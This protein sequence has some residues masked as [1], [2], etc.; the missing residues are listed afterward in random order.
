MDN[1]LAKHL[2]D[3]FLLLKK[4][5]TVNQ[6]IIEYGNFEIFDNKY[7]LEINKN[8]IVSERVGYW[9]DKPVLLFNNYKYVLLE[10]SHNI[11]KI[12]KLGLDDN[13]INNRPEINKE[14]E[15]KKITD[16]LIN[17]ISNIIKNNKPVIDKT[18]VIVKS[19]VITKPIQKPEVFIKNR[20]TVA[21]K[22][23]PITPPPVVAP[24]VELLKKSENVSQQIPQ[25]VSTVEDDFFSL[26]EKHKDDKR[27]TK[28]FNYHSE[29]A[30]KELFAITEKFNKQQKIISSEGGGGTN[31][32]QFAK[33]GIMGGDLTIEG[34]VSI[35]GILTGG[36]IL[37]KKIFT[38]GNN[39]DNELMAYTFAPK[40]PD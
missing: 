3:A 22:A 32:M 12:D 4:E 38:I 21:P 27:I 23:E 9:K 37:N 1:I 40:S 34:N 35:T 13:S 11:I 18:P 25:T 39:I 19:S 30:K 36:G 20:E 24:Y 14:Q 28:F 31:A 33:G 29:L 10:N 8:T 17:S 16:N 7:H 5:P 15:E 26:L 6:D 2:A